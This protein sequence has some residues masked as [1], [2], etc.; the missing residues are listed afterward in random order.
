MQFCDLAAPLPVTAYVEI[1]HNSMKILR[2]QMN[3]MRSL[4]CNFASSANRLILEA[5][6]HGSLSLDAALDLMM[7][8]APA[9]GEFKSTRIDFKGHRYNF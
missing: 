6:M 7:A 8:N 5:K 2:Q 4:I 1:A 3:D 9:S